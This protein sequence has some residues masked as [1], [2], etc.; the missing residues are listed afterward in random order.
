MARR[1]KY[2]PEKRTWRGKSYKTGRRVREMKEKPD[3]SK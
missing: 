1:K 2:N 3:A